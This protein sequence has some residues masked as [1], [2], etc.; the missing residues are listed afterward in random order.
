[1]RTSV[2]PSKAVCRT[3]LIAWAI[4]AVGIPARGQE[5]P[6]LSATISSDYGEIWNGD[7]AAIMAAPPAAEYPLE[8]IPDGADPAALA[9]TP[10]GAEC[11]GCNG[12]GAGGF[13]GAYPYN[14]CGCS[15]HL[16]P[17]TTGPGNCD[18]W[19]VGPHWDVS[20]DGLIMF[21]ENADWARVVTDV[22]LVPD[23][24]DQFDHGPGVRLFVTGYN[25][26]SYGVQV[27]Y[28]GVNDFEA[29]A[30]FPQVGSLRSFAYE[31]TINSVEV[32]LFRRTKRPWKVFAGARY[33]EIDEDFVDFTT[34]DKP[35]PAPADPPPA[36]VAFI[37]AGNSFFLENRLMGFQLGVFRDVWQLNRWITIEPFGNAGVYLNDFKR[38][39]VAHTITTVVTGDDLGTTANEFSQ[40]A[41]DV[42]T[43]VRRDFTDV[44]FLG[45]AGV[46]AVVRLN[47]CVALRAGYQALATDGV[48]QGLDAFFASGLEPNRLFYHGAQFG[49][50]YVR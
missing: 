38:E 17:Y 2:V 40:T 1:M 26:G 4:G 42:N 43:V 32:N 47:R 45:E 31:S 8:P 37:D 34:V 49:V 39:N 27:G 5:A 9:G 12:G 28:E 41:T 18:N 22:G 48:G 24:V 11:A 20:L 29:T 13:Y 6:S 14:R 19:C 50:E 21:R 7:S 44:A 16:F 23:L 35:L 36:A 33:V 15:A 3:L 10:M 25:C 46:T 30:L